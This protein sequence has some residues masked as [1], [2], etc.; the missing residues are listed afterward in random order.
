MSDSIYKQGRPFW[1]GIARQIQEAS[2]VVNQ[3]TDGVLD[4]MNLLQAFL[5]SFAAGLEVV[6]S[7]KNENDRE[8]VQNSRKAVI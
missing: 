5:G 2:S 1:D 3:E 8:S 6:W 7:S 4:I